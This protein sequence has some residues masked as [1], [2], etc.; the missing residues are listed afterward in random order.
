MAKKIIMI[1]TARTG[2]SYFR[3]YVVNNFKL[4]KIDNEIY[5]RFVNSKD[6]MSKVKKYH[7]LDDSSEI[8]KNH[9]ELFTHDYFSIEQ[10]LK[11]NQMLSSLSDAIK[12]K[13][14]LIKLTSNSFKNQKK[15]DEFIKIKNAEFFFLTRNVLDVIISQYKSGLTK[16]WQNKDTTDL[17]PE[18]DKDFFLN[19]YRATSSWFLKTY[20]LINNDNKPRI[21]RYEQIF[22]NKNNPD[23]VISDFFKE[24]VEKSKHSKKYPPLHK[25]DLNQVWQEK[26]SN[27][28]EIENL[29]DKHKIVENYADL[30]I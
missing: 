7:K 9:I 5:H 4:L 13:G 18:L 24:Y 15:L 8:F 1:S 30:L 21:I 6:A 12:A 27:H 23:D 10:P 26:I 29:I 22:N 19:T 2:A 3:K 16:S 28:E 11:F 25:Q 20:E 17:K 14:I